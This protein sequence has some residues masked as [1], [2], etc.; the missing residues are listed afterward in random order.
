MLIQIL[1]GFLLA[2]TAAFAAHRL[3]ALTRGGAVAATVLGT[4]VFGLGGWQW[5]AL[6]LA[7][8]ILSSALSRLFQ[9]AKRSVEEKYAKGSERDQMQV[10]SNGGLAGIFVVLHTLFPQSAWTWIGFAGALAAV[11]ADTWATE[12]GVL[13][14]VQPRL[15]TSLRK[16]VEKGTSGGVSVVGTLASLLAAAVIAALAALL[17]PQGSWALVLAVTLAGLIGSLVDSLLGATLQAIYFC[18]LDQK[19]TEKHPLHTCGTPTV[20]IRG[21]SWLNNDWVNI[22]CSIAGALAALG[23]ALLLKIG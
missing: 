16:R 5:A 21:W 11:N 18:P 20:Q 15:I 3:R 12:L 17:A 6:L 23:L 14:P 8:F 1:A 2:A 10:F 4:V 22:A 9:R 19:E 13:N 7:F